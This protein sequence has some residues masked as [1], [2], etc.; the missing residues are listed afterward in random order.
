MSGAFTG[1]KLGDTI[2]TRRI[3][4]IREPE[5]DSDG[6]PIWQSLPV[7]FNL[8]KFFRINFSDFAAAKSSH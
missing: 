2:N 8:S 5:F 4:A 6:T 3:R 1:G 7:E